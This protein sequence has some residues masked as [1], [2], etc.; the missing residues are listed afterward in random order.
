MDNDQHSL[1]IEIHSNKTAY[2]YL[3]APETVSRLEKLAESD[4]DKAIQISDQLKATVFQSL[5]TREYVREINVV[6]SSMRGNLT[7]RNY[8]FV[9]YKLDRVDQLRTLALQEE[10]NYTRTVAFIGSVR[11]D[12]LSSQ[13]Y[14]SKWQLVLLSQAYH[15]QR[16]LRGPSPT[17]HRPMARAKVR[18]HEPRT[19][20]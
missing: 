13:G 20:R 16:T 5:L 7:A 12:I 18:N 10:D 6:V 4:F 15:D 9:L 1:T 11:Q 19:F 14:L 17:T 8:E 2:F 3:D